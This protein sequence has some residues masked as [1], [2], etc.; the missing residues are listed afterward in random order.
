[1]VVARERFFCWV[2]GS[3]LFVGRG[4]GLGVPVGGVARGRLVLRVLVAGVRVVLALI[5]AAVAVG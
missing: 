2:G 3:G 5:R 1:M 4:F